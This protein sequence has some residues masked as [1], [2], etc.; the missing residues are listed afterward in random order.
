MPCRLH[1]G[2]Q[3]SNCGFDFFSGLMRECHP[4]KAPDDQQHEHQRDV[5]DILAQ[6]L[7]VARDKL[8]ASL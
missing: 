1:A 6:H 3:K 8:Q 4:D 2:L 5:A 7:D